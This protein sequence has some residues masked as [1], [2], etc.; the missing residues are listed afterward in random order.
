MLGLV[1]SRVLILTTVERI[2]LGYFNCSS[3][4]RQISNTRFTSP[5]NKTRFSYW[6]IYYNSWFIDFKSYFIDYA[7]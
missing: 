3:R 4:M 5:L 2:E 6:I 1:S 7:V